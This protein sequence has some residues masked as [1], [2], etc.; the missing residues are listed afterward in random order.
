MS[1]HYSDKSVDVEGFDT[2]YIT[3][4]IHKIIEDILNTNQ[5]N[6]ESI[7]TWSRQ[8]VDSCQQSLSK[9][10]GSFKTI[11]T[12]MIIPKMDESIHM[13]NACRWDF[14]VDGSTIIK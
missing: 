2:T 12:T 9:I 10:Y 8:I 13:S 5:F 3:D 14:L 1:V 6:R 11:I 4:I 7:D